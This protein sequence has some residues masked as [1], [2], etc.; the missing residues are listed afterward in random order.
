VAVVLLCMVGCDI[1]GCWANHAFNARS[2]HLVR[3]AI[4][5]GKIVL[6]TPGAGKP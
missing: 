4:A 2:D 3:Q 5:A 6:S 1:A